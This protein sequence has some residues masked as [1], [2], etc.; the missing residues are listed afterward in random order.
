MKNIKRKSLIKAAKKEAKKNIKSKLIT[1][2][3]R[4]LSTIGSGSAK[5]EKTIAKGSSKLAK[6]I[7]NEI[8]LD[9]VAIVANAQ[10]LKAEQPEAATAETPAKKAA[11]EK[12]FAK[13]AKTVKKEAVVTAS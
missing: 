2:L 7:A 5:L 8:Q 12:G 10:P 6:K 1:E 11:V 9:E 13:K 3:K 4:V